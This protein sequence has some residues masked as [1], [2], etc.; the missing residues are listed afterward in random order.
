[1]ID[2]FIKYLHN[3]I[4]NIFFNTIYNSIEQKENIKT[5]LSNIYHKFISDNTDTEFHIKILVILKR[6]VKEEIEY[7]KNTKLTKIHNESDFFILFFDDYLDLWKKS[8]VLNNIL[9]PIYEAIVIIGKYSRTIVN[10]Y[11]I[12]TL[13]E[14]SWGILFDSFK[15][16]F[17][18][19]LNHFIYNQ[20]ENDKTKI[21]N[22]LYIMKNHYSV[23]Y[24]NIYNEIIDNGYI[25]CQKLY[26][27]S[28]DKDLTIIKYIEEYKI[29]TIL[30]ENI[31]TNYYNKTDCSILSN[32][33][34]YLYFKTKESNHLIKKLYIEFINNL[35]INKL[36]EINKY[37][38]EFLDTTFYIELLQIVVD[39]VTIE[40]DKND[41]LELFL[42]VSTK[43]K[44]MYHLN[45]YKTYIESIIYNKFLYIKEKTEL[46]KQLILLV[47]GDLKKNIVSEYLNIL[48]FLDKDIFITYYIKYLCKRI[49]N[50]NYTIETE[51]KYYNEL[52]Y[53]EIED[54][55]KVEFIIKDI[56]INDSLR[57]II[58]FEKTEL[59]VVRDYIWPIKKKEDNI[60]T[61]FLNEYNMIK[62][63]YENSF[64]QKKLY[65]N[66]DLLRCEISFNGYTLNVK[67]YYVDFLL[68]FNDT[69]C[70]KKH[71]DHP[72]IEKF[73][74]LKM[75]KEDNSSYIIND[76]FKYKKNYIKIS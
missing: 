47:I 23:K 61:S 37:F 56:C 15:T 58:N 6:I 68:L 39:K 11:K 75:I 25:F 30:V 10:E 27:N 55:Y 64:K 74:K 71:K 49:I 19:Y 67:G 60:P 46:E 34:V 29:N 32:K 57:E 17:T 44:G 52:F 20:Y 31:S 3:I 48:V 62:T 45:I 63:V 16:N 54:I 41:D 4:H 8:I 59:L 40:S 14:N 70:I 50:K 73:I 72:N 65:L 33:I 38:I 22:I 66:T 43:C 26:T 51:L 9:E 28:L 1:M 69:S 42:D 21:S 53:Y 35:E 18:S 36:K 5:N 13:L 12:N 7:Y 24:S 76:N 2:K